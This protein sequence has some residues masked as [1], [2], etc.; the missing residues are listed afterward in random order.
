MCWAG[1]CRLEFRPKCQTG[2]IFFLKSASHFRS[3]LL[4]ELNLPQTKSKGHS[5]KFYWSQN[6]KASLR[7]VRT[8]L[9]C[10]L[11][12]I[13]D[14][15]LIFTAIPLEY[16]FLTHSTSVLWSQTAHKS[17]PEQNSITLVFQGENIAPSNIFLSP[18]NLSLAS[19]EYGC[20]F[21]F[22]GQIVPDKS[23]FSY[24]GRYVMLRAQKKYFSCSYWPRLTKEALP[25]IVTDFNR[26]RSPPSKSSISLELTCPWLFIIVCRYWRSRYGESWVV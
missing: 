6:A 5:N 8:S 22:Y 18:T 13:T 21:D 17:D 3:D 11:D 7:C 12:W 24:D 23:D 2:G 20:S 16:E 10:L 9:L 25:Y 14:T 26:V 1:D 4:R 19:E 15:P